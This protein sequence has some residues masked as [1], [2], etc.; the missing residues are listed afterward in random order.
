[1]ILHAKGLV[2][3]DPATL[4]SLWEK[5][6]VKTAFEPPGTGNP[7]RPAPCGHFTGQICEACSTGGSFCWCTVPSALAATLNETLKSSAVA[8]HEEAHEEAIT[9]RAVQSVDQGTAAGVL[10]HHGTHWV[11]VYG[12]LPANPAA[13]TAITHL[14]VHDPEFE[15]RS[16]LVTTNNWLAFWLTDIRCGRYRPYSLGVTTGARLQPPKRIAPGVKLDPLAVIVAPTLIS[17]QARTDAEWLR[18][19]LNWDAS[20]RQATARDPIF[21]RDDTG[22]SRD[23]YLVDFRTEDRPTA[24]MIYDA[25]MRFGPQYAGVDGDA[26][27]ASAALPPL[28]SAADVEQ[29]ERSLYP[30]PAQIAVDPTPLW[31]PCDQSHSPY[32]PFYKVRRDGAVEYVRVDGMI[33]PELTE[34]GGGA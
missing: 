7:K 34:V 11:V 25:R 10:V 22:S 2:A 13:G 32:Q 19:T 12:Y 9:M 27:G 14:Y 33:F 5:I 31:R 4:D 3:G 23:Y 18:T 21:V 1:M 20:L 29:L 6:K 8:V 17:V 28:L 15:A 16:S 24:R 30:G 26:G